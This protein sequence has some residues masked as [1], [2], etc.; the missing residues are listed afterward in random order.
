MKKFL[1]FAVLVAA[2]GTVVGCDSKPTTAPP[3]KTSPNPSG[4]PPAAKTT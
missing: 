1:C 2:L 4:T 3:G